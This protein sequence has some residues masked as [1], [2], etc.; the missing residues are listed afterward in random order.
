MKPGYGGHVEDLA[1]LLSHHARQHCCDGMQV[2]ANISVDHLIPIDDGNVLPVRKQHQTCV[3]HKA[4]NLSVLGNCEFDEIL[5]A[6]VLG[7]VGK[8]SYISSFSGPS[9]MRAGFELYRSFA[10]DAEFNR[11]QLAA[12]G[13]TKIPV[14]ALAGESSAFSTI[15][16]PMMEEVADSVSFVIIDKAV[17]WLAEENP[18]AVAQSLIDFDALMLG[19]DS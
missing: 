17:H 9:G 5:E 16:K 13:K 1:M 2:T 18:T 6:S 4:F 14:L 8:A 3:V 7:N 19:Y 11:A 15:I 12:H 10:V